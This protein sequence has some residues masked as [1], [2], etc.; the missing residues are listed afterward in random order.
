MIFFLL[1]HRLID[2]S[3]LLLLF[4]L[5]SHNKSSDHIQMQNRTTRNWDTTKLWANHS[6]QTTKNVMVSLFDQ[7]PKRQSKVTAVVTRVIP[8]S[9]QR[10]NQNLHPRVSQRYCDEYYVS[11]K[12]R[13]AQT[14]RWVLNVIAAHEA[15]QK[16]IKFQKNNTQTTIIPT[17]SVQEN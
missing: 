11:D 13:D 10:T 15:Y 14:G 16:A 6:Q 8:V 3:L 2:N 12:E 7:R 5:T 1:H 4:H 9:I 17:I